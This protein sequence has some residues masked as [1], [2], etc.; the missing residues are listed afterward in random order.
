[1][2]NIQQGHFSDQLCLR[3]WPGAFFFQLFPAIYQS[4]GKLGTELRDHNDAVTFPFFTFKNVNCCG[5]PGS[6]LFLNLRR[7]NNAT[8]NQGLNRTF[9]VVVAFF[10]QLGDLKAGHGWFVIHHHSP[11]CIIGASGTPS[12]WMCSIKPSWRRLSPSRPSADNLNPNSSSAIT[13]S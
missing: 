4:G 10:Y 2:L 5:A 7:S 6:R 12:I 9:H 8:H 1:M 13:M 3:F 11:Q